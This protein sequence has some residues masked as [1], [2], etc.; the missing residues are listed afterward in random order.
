MCLRRVNSDEANFLSLAVHVNSDGVA[1]DELT[2]RVQTRLVVGNDLE[3]DGD[4]A[5]LVGEE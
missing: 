5:G 1:I 2:D 4:P 3:I